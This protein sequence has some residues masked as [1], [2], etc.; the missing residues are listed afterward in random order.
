M[1]GDIWLR[2]GG[3]QVSGMSC[4]KLISSLLWILQGFFHLM[5]PYLWKTKPQLSA[6]HVYIT[7]LIICCILY[8]QEFNNLI[9]T[10]FSTSIWLLLNTYMLGFGGEQHKTHDSYLLVSGENRQKMKKYPWPGCCILE[11]RVKKGDFTMQTGSE[12]PVTWQTLQR[13]ICR[14]WESWYRIREMYDL[15][16]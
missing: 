10:S 11:P 12:P 16:S 1:S 2:S 6:A 13:M 15:T 9:L 14:L 7:Q 4:L 5:S 3:G 8:S